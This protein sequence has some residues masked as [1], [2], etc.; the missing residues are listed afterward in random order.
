MDWITVYAPATI[1]NIGPGFD[2]LGLAV[3]HVGDT[4]EARRIDR[5]VVLSSVET[6]RAT[7]EL[8]ADAAENTAGI[9]AREVLS[10]LGDPGGVELRLKKGIPC[11]S[12]LGSSAASAAAGA[13]AVNALYGGTLSGNELVLAATRAEAVV[14]GGY[15]ADNTAPSILGGAT[16][17]RCGDPLDVTKIG[18]VSALTIVLVTPQ[19]VVLTRTAREILPRQVPMEGFVANMANACLITAAFAKDDY[20]LFSR[21]LRDVVVQPYRSKLI[22]GFDRVVRGALGAGA[23]GVAISGSGPTMFAVTNSARTA[24]AI[25]TAMVDA[26]AAEGV[27]STSLITEIDFTGTRQL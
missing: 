23:D 20:A 16:L 1:G 8:S 22:T 15:F 24:R 14:S 7:D 9:A 17:T 19:L 11:G 10:M 6:V 12:G 2:V 5:G 13:F 25:E 21:C 4:V 18:T 3:R 26:F 27:G